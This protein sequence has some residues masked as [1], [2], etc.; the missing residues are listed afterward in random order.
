MIALFWHPNSFYAALYFVNPEY[1]PYVSLAVVQ[2]R[3]LL[4]ALCEPYS[5]NTPVSVLSY[6][7]SHSL[8]LHGA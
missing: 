8:Q 2:A 6:L 4:F 1:N 7:E 5:H 3:E